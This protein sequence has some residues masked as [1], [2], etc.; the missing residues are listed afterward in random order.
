MIHFLKSYNNRTFFLIIIIMVGLIAS[1]A[2]ISIATGGLFLNFLLSGNLKQSFRDFIHDKKLFVL[3]LF[4]L[5]SIIA[6]SYSSNIPNGLRFIVNKTYFFII[7]LAISRLTTFK[8]SHLNSLLSVFVGIIFIS[9]LVVLIN[10]LGNM[11]FYNE[12]LR[13]GGV[14]WT[15]ISHIRYSLMLVLAMV[16]SFYL[17][18]NSHDIFGHVQL[19]IKKYGK[20][21]WG[22]IGVFL[23]ILTHLLSVRSG[24]LVLYIVLLF[25]AVKSVFIK[26]K[27]LLGTL[28]LSLFFLIPTASY[29]IFDSFKN[30][31]DY[32]KYDIE[33]FRKND[34]GNNSDARRLLSYKIGWEIASEYFPFGCGTGELYQITQSHYVKNY[35][36]VKKEN[37]LLPHNQF[38]WTL[39]EYGIIGLITLLI[40]L[41]YPIMTLNW[42]KNSLFVA[43]WIIVFFSL[44]VEATFEV[45]L[46]I[47]FFTLFYSLL[48]KKT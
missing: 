2:L 47:S 45:Q 48:L 46:G 3:S 36:D 6:L 14:I 39:A 31:I 12:R 24:I 32:M 18:K 17:S 11:A 34:I 19:I 30:K 44:F 33:Q 28:L 26:K 10:Y 8:A 23:F 25:F 40:G 7:P 16:S 4:L 9:G 5:S 37:R 22:F 43:L 41:F 38:L 29:H 21:G 35:P 1:R 27:Y 15:P 42:F 13:A 20:W